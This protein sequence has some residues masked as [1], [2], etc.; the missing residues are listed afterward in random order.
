MH[1]WKKATHSPS[2]EYQLDLLRD[3]D[4]S[5]RAS[6]AEELGKGEASSSLISSLIQMGSE[7]GG[8]EASIPYAGMA[9]VNLSPRASES[10]R[11]K[12]WR[13]FTTIPSDPD[14][15]IRRLMFL[16]DAFPGE[17][18]EF[19]PRLKNLMQTSDAR[20]EFG[21][22]SKVR[23]AIVKFIA[24]A[25]HNPSSLDQSISEPGLWKKYKDQVI[26]GA[27]LKLVPKNQSGNLQIVFATVLRVENVPG[28]V[29][30]KNGQPVDILIPHIVASLPAAAGLSSTQQQ[31]TLEP[32]SPHCPF[33]VYLAKEM[34]AM[35]LD[36][37][38][39]HWVTTSDP[40]AKSFRNDEGKSVGILLKRQKDVCT[41]KMMRGQVPWILDVPCST[42]G[43][44]R[45]APAWGRPW[46]DTGSR[47]SVGD[48]VQLN[49]EA[50]EFKVARHERDLIGLSPL[51][52]VP[53]KQLSPMG[54]IWAKD[55]E[56]HYLGR[57]APDGT[58][59]KDPH[60]SSVKK[61]VPVN[62]DMEA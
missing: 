61:T 51:N 21:Q 6:A 32:I 35:P 27:K 11:D 22:N 62:P 2:V 50:G 29:R 43:P 45:E 33:D 39:G 52:H 40:L 9:L 28:R 16:K 15:F 30:G 47:F 18:H 49:G 46:F 59:I 19:V 38:K 60:L 34:E 4:N 1:W 55:S 36:Q 25:E 37:Y 58:I 53:G 13:L 42:V 20:G 12:I 7:N 8:F 57:L 10:D 17:I 23:Q 14:R 41:L 54:L 56:V 44:T 3:G 31:I 48:V 5:E 26:P 24:A